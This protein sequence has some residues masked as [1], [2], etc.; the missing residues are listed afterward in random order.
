M[1]KNS[2]GGHHLI[3]HRKRNLK[4]IYKETYKREYN[5]YENINNSNKLDITHIKNY[6]PRYYGCFHN[7]V[8]KKSDSFSSLSDFFDENKY[9]Y[10]DEYFII[11]ED[12]CFGY[13]FPCILDLKIGTRQF[14]LN[15]DNDKIKRKTIK[16]NISLTK[17]YGF[18]IAGCKYDD[19]LCGKKDCLTFSYSQA[20]NMIFDFCSCNYDIAKCFYNKLIEFYNDMQ[21]I[22]K[23]FRFYTSSLLLIYDNNNPI[24]TIKIAMIDFAHTYSINELSD[25]QIIDKNYDDGYIFGI[26]NLIKL[27][28]CIIKK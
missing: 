1:Y 6:I 9:I 18:R 11:L 17:N 19:V 10:N 4:Q 14:G 12:L 23:Y 7:D 2:V 8:V 28:E 5:F 24:N 27:F 15:C 3:L 25:E 22:N 26:K 21:N 20:K 13:K 16:E